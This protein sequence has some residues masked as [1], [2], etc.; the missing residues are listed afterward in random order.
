MPNMLGKA[1]GAGARGVVVVVGTTG[2]RVKRG[3]PAWRQPRTIGLIRLAL[4]VED[5]PVDVR[6][7]G[8]VDHVNCAML[9]W[10]V[11]WSRD[12]GQR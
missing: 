3:V 6:R 2:R 1:P 10:P 11:A 8:S 4:Q 9:F 12:D 5:S 7:I